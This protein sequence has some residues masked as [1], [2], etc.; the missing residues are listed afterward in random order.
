[1]D[2]VI[3]SWQASVQIEASGDMLEVKALS[4]QAF[5]A[6][7]PSGGV[8]DDEEY[9]GVTWTSTLEVLLYLGGTL[10]P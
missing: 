9:L 1:M 3:E 6:P 7:C 4:S 5:P 10:V 2:Y 8:S